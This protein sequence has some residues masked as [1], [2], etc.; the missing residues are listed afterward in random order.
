MKVII[1][2]AGKGTRLRPHT[3]LKPKPLLQVAGQPVIRYVLEQLKDFGHVDE[4][5]F[6]TGHLKEQI[7]EYIH[8]EFPEFKSRF[9][10]QEEQKGTAHAVE[11][12]KPYVD[13][14]VLIVF[15]DTLFEADLAEID[16]L[17]SDAA[18]IIWAKHVEDHEQFGVVVQDDKSFM[19]KIVEKPEEPISKLANIGV[20]YVRDY[21][22]LFEGID[23]ILQKSPGQGG[24][25][26]L[27]DA[28]QYMIDNGAK[29]KVAEVQG[30]YDCGKLQT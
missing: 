8:K 19:T 9:I 30:W 3:H 29:I 21:K 15:V 26:V 16:R 24:E 7:E 10:E 25:Y 27:T 5:I 14:D 11:L 17:P 20:Y 2:L 22:L 6:I 18:G 1:P 13:E 28:F 12:A 4:I 23:S